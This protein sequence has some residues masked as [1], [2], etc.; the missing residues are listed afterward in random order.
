MKP[1]LLKIERSPEHSFSI[2][3]DVMPRFYN[4]WHYHP[5]IELVYIIRGTG[6]QFIGD[7][8]HHFK[9]GDMILLGQ[10]LPHLWRSDDRFL[11]KNSRL[12]VEAIILHFTAECFGENFFQLPENKTLRHLFERASQAVRIK[13]ATRDQVG[14]LLKDLLT[15]TH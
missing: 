9:P 1:D 4:K 2:R 3:H 14:I 7:N 5:E 13:N 6:R 15:A 12:K 8:I 11:V 10:N